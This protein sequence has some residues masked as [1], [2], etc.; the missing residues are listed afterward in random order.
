MAIAPEVIAQMEAAREMPRYKSHKQVWALEILQVIDQRGGEREGCVTLT[1]LGWPSR[2]LPA[3][4]DLLKR[5]QP[6]DGDFLVVYNKGTPD[7]YESFSPRKQF[8]EGYVM[9]DDGGPRTGEAEAADAKCETATEAAREFGV[10]AKSD[11]YERELALN[12]AIKMSPVTKPPSAD[13]IVEAAGKFLAFL[14]GK[15]A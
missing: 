6:K 8:L 10:T 3:G 5:Y 4:H 13:E 15:A 14:N 7:E 1:F 12:A 9:I 2:I 11:L